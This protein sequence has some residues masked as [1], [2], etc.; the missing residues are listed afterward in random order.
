MTNI[1]LF[2]TLDHCPM[3]S[4]FHAIHLAVRREEM[5]IL[6]S[7][8]SVEP[9][10]YHAYLGKCRYVNFWFKWWMNVYVYIYIYIFLYTHTCVYMYCIC[11]HYL[12]LLITT[13]VGTLNDGIEPTWVFQ[14]FWL[15]LGWP[16]LASDWTS[17]YKNRIS[18]CGG[19]QK[20]GYPSSS[21][22]LFSDVPSDFHV[23]V[24]P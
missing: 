18:P 22:I 5:S 19:F 15:L 20:W 1:W 21:S 9:W 2:C 7:C 8:V 6:P 4:F 11:M 3:S 10:M 14:V 23:G 12:Q 13:T 17:E 16:L 24:P